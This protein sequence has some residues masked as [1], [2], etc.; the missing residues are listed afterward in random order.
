[1][2]LACPVNPA[3]P[4]LSSLITHGGVIAAATYFLSFSVC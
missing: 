3:T 2:L 4:M 1:L